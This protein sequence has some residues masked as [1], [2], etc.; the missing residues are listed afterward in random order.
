MLNSPTERDAM[1]Q[2][3]PSRQTES[4]A[5]TSVQLFPQ[6][7]LQVLVVPE[8]ASYRSQGCSFKCWSAAQTATFSMPTCT[9]KSAYK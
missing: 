2:N 4:T 7:K 1:R 3:S 9:V 8:A 6:T 5:H